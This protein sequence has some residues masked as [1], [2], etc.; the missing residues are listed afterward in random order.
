MLRNS[1]GGGGVSYKEIIVACSSHV[2][3]VCSDLS[4]RCEYTRRTVPLLFGCLVQGPPGEIESGSGV[5]SG[6]PRG[7]MVTAS[8]ERRLCLSS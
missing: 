6:L 1:G 8:W 5:R 7:G 3:G 4:Q 2:A